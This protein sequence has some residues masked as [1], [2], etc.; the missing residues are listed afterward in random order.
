M[1]SSSSRAVG[2]RVRTCSNRRTSSVG[3]APPRTASSKSIR[4]APARSAGGQ[5]PSSARSAPT[6]RW[7]C[8]C[9]VA[10]ARDCS[11]PMGD[12][13][14]SS[15]T[16]T[17]SGARGTGVPSG[18]KPRRP[19]TTNRPGATAC[20]RRGECGCAGRP[21]EPAGHREERVR[22]RVV[23]NE[24][25]AD[26]QATRAALG[27][28]PDVDARAALGGGRVTLVDRQSPRANRHATRE[29]RLRPGHR[30]DGLAAPDQRTRQTLDTQGRRRR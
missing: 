8:A 12:S 30:G 5:V 15:P 7:T 16:S 11:G 3:A 17:V 26:R 19:A 4:A 25:L 6:G 21:G 10:S 23:E 29:R 2:S 18:V 20:R 1:T 9:A 13:G 24:Q 27:A 28:A 14:P 22:A